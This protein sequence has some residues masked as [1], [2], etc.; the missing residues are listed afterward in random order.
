MQRPNEK[1]TVERKSRL[2]LAGT[3]SIELLEAPWNA[4]GDI[5]AAVTLRGASGGRVEGYQGFNLAQHVGDRP[6]RVADNR[7][8]LAGLLDADLEWH[9][10]DQVHGSDVIVVSEETRSGSLPKADALVTSSRQQACCILT[11]DC[12]PVFFYS[13]SL[14]RV[15]VAHAGWRGL[16]GGVLEATLAEFDQ[17]PSSVSVWFG[18]AIG[19]CHFEV[20]EDV[21]RAFLAKSHVPDSDAAFSPTG[22]DGKYM[23]DLTRLARSR[24]LAAGV[25]DISGDELCTYCSESEFYSYRREAKSGRMLSVIYIK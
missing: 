23:A 22:R 6:E 18:P 20:G 3:E 12:L 7:E 2:A 9:W 1:H 11:A 21:R 13:R 19:P 25:S 16:A 10:L 24:L 8:A 15:A 4:K 17:D 14:R 5:F